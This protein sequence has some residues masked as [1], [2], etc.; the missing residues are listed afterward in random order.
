MKRQ[1][2]QSRSE[3]AQRGINLKDQAQAQSGE[4][5]D[6]HPQGHFVADR[7]KEIT[8]RCKAAIEGSGTDDKEF[9]IYKVLAKQTSSDDGVKYQSQPHTHFGWQREWPRVGRRLAVPAAIARTLSHSSVLCCVVFSL[10]FI[11]HTTMARLI[12]PAR[13]GS[14]GE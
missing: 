7:I 5:H 4:A 12:R 10:Q 1:F 9:K 6:D 11:G 2:A 13:R 3:V 14:R 8:D